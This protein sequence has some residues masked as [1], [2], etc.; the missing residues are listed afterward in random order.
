VK[1]FFEAFGDVF[2]GV[3]E[4]LGGDEEQIS[5]SL[6]EELADATAHTAHDGTF[7]IHRSQGSLSSHSIITKLRSSRTVKT[8]QIYTI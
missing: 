6:L 7:L 5:H 8:P 3:F 1:L 2:S 4:A